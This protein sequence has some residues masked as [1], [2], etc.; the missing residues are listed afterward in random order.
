MIDV[1]MIVPLLPYPVMDGDSIRHYNLI[2]RLASECNIHLFAFAKEEHL[3]MGLKEMNKYCAAVH[4]IPNR[5]MPRSWWLRQHAKSI[6]RGAP[7]YAS[8]HYRQ[9][10][11]ETV[12]E[13]LRK[14]RFD[15]IQ[16]EHSF[17]AE[18]LKDA[19]K[20]QSSASTILTI[21]NIEAIRAYRVYKHQRWGKAKIIYAI[22]AL[23]FR[24]FEPWAIKLPDKCITVSEANK[25]QLESTTGNKDIIVIENGVDTDINPVSINPDSKEL[26][27]I[28][29]LSYHPN[30]DGAEYIT[31]EILPLIKEQIPDIQLNI[32]GKAPCPRVLVLDKVDNVS[33]YGDVPDVR[34]WYER[35]IMSVVPLRSGGGTRLKILESMGLGVPVVTTSIGCEGLDVTHEEH[36]LIA[37]TPVEFAA[38]VLKLIEDHNLRD[39]LIRNA[40]QL[41]ERRY[42]WDAIAPQLLSVYKSLLNKS[43]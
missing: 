25:C 13:S 30:V 17:L 1:M 22:D 32:V 21:H 34:P 7:T 28:G 33:V 4:A 5:K 35:S 12:T 41:V 24:R 16:V 37:D 20:L 27:F 10:M 39:R 40:R 14:Y 19:I 8:A 23:L 42:S 43:N 3:D 18:Y 29:G 11:I 31:N 15:I 9:Q 6:L 26:L 2:K 36:L 38:C